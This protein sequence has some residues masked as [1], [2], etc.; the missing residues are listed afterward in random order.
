MEDKRLEKAREYA[1]QNAGSGSLH[2]GPTA[3]AAAIMNQLVA[4]AEERLRVNVG[5]L[6]ENASLRAKL[7][8]PET[9]IEL[10]DIPSQDLLAELLR[11]GAVTVES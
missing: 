6:N 7:R 5:L 4:Y 8:Q 11:R 9:E 2:E 1:R 10:P 3:Y